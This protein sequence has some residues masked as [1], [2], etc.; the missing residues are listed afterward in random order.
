MK[1]NQLVLAHFFQDIKELKNLWEARSLQLRLLS[2]SL[3]IFLMSRIKAKADQEQ[4]RTT[5]IMVLLETWKFRDLT[6]LDIRMPNSVIE[7]HNR[8]IQ[9]KRKPT[10]HLLYNNSLGKLLKRITIKKIQVILIETASRTCSNR[11]LWINKDTS[12][13]KGQ[14][15]IILITHNLSIRILTAVEINHIIGLNKM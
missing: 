9:L 6:Q 4:E 15:L 2:L 8:W 11:T 1:A 5:K 13:I 3:M 10:I 12:L 7:I 14:I